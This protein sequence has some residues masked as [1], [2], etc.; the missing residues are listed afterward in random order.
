MA[1]LRWL[2]RTALSHPFA[3]VLP[4]LVA[5]AVILSMIRTGTSF[6]G[7]EQLLYTQYLDLGYGRSQPPLFTWALWAVQQVFGAGQLA[8]NILRAG[9]IGAGL[10]G[11]DRLSRQLGHSRA[12]A[13]LVVFAA[14]LIPEVSVEMPRKYSHSL[15]LF[16]LLPYA[17]LV[18]LRLRGHARRSDYATLG[19]IFAALVLCKYNALVFIAALVAADLLTRR[20]DSVFARRAALVTLVVMGL[21]V[22]PHVVWAVG[23]LQHVTALTGRFAMTPE[24]GF[25]RAQALGTLSFAGALVS[26]LGLVLVLAAGTAGRRLPALFTA[27]LASPAGLLLMTAVLFLISSFAAMLVSNATNVA[28]RWM[29]P[30]VVP[31]LPVLVGELCTAFARGPRVMG[32]AAG[33]VLAVTVP[34]QWIDSARFGPHTFWDYAQLADDL[35]RDFAPDHLLVGDFQALANLRLYR[36]DLPYDSPVMPRTIGQDRAHPVLVWLGTAAAPTD[37]TDWA[38]GRGLCPADTPARAYRIPSVWSD[39]R[40]DVSATALIPCGPQPETEAPFG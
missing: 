16:A 12:V 26:L 20:G 5:Q 14:F 40:L 31:L 25:P 24:L 33:L 2:R 37:L 36:P 10:Y 11:L 39:A 8:E 32:W 27:P 23:N 3:L 18:V 30:V 6:D 28:T 7:A 4:L 21:A 17:C 13:A 9:L 29:L 1:P 38:R 22:L 19:L 34:G 35:D 15:T